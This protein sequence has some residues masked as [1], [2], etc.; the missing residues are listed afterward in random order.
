MISVGTFIKEARVKKK[1]S[2][3]KLEKLTKIKS[4]F[5][6]S[7]EKEDWNNLPE[8]PVVVGLSKASPKL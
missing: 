8:Y 2:R 5:L 7:I 6:E 1:L 3:E 4:S